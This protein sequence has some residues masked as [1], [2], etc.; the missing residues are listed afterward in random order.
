[1]ARPAEHAW[2]V[3]AAD[4][5]RPHLAALLG[6]STDPSPAD[7][8]RLVEVKATI[9][10]GFDA[11][12]AAGADPASAGL[13]VDEEYGAEV[14]RDAVAAGRLVAMPVEASGA[15][16]FTLA[17]PGIVDRVLALRPGCVKALVRYNVEG[18]PAGRTASESAL[19]AL[20]ARLDAETPRLMIEVVVPPTPEQL[21]EAGSVDAFARHR[22]PALIARAVRALRATGADPDLWK[23]EGID[24]ADDARGD[25][26]AARADGGVAGLVVLGAGAPAA[27]VAHWLRI[28]AGT[29]GYVGFAI[30]RSLWWDEILDRL[31]GRTDR[32]TASRRIATNFLDAVATYEAG[33]R[34]RITPSARPDSPRSG[35]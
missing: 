29:P 32:D 9:A 10:A 12:I 16:H 2:Y 24:D 25:A 35:A 23:V 21:A 4:H 3:L 28:A 8:P 33:R 31:A 11:A 15:G 13:L 7:R 17:D 22:R 26:D 14:A 34:G 6:R 1:M 5:R 27:R 18:D 30:G 20:A 19:V